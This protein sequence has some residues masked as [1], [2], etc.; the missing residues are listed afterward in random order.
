MFLQIIGPLGC[1]AEVF[2]IIQDINHIRGIPCD[3]LEESEF[4][5]VR[6]KTRLAESSLQNLAQRLDPDEEIAATPLKRSRIMAIADLYRLAALLYAQRVHP[7]ADADARRTEYLGK[8]Y[9]VLSTLHVA[10]CPWPIFVLACESQSEE[11]RAFMMEV[12]DRMSSIRAVGN[13][14]VMRKIVEAFW[15][16]NDLQETNRDSPSLKWWRF[17][18]SDTA[19]P[20]FV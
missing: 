16:R 1:S 2:H 8:A 7:A 18:D 11:E 6:E 3:E 19:A 20:W 13:V 9:Q 17:Y 4:R 5:S 15:K 10:S 12:L 14:G